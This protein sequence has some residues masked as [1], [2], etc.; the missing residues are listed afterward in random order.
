MLRSLFK[1]WLGEKVTQAG[2]WLK[3]DAGTYQRFHD[4]VVPS[5]NGTTQVDHI[6][7]S[8]YGVFVLETKNYNGWIFGDEHALKWTVSH[9]GKKFQFQNPLRQNFRHIQC[10]SEHLRLDPAVFHSV[11]F[12]IGDAEIKTPMPRNVVS[13]GLASYIQS[14][15]APCLSLQQVTEIVAALAALKA[16]P[17]LTKAHHL[18]SLAARRA[19]TTV[20]PTCGSPLIER[21][22]RSGANAGKP[23]LGCKSYPRCRYTKTI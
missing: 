17:I 18:E 23:F 7:V 9:F 8:V 11:V 6:L 5:R 2:M 10:L 4:V 21:V 19:S 20:C 13:V 12:F 16:N 3:L 14:F 22:A 1:A 15:T